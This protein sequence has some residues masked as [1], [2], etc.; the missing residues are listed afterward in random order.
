MFVPIVAVGRQRIHIKRLCEKCLFFY[1]NMR[2][3]LKIFSFDEIP[4][5]SKLVMVLQNYKLSL[6]KKINVYHNFRQF[7]FQI[8]YILLFFILILIE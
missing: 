4:L 7:T 2:K 6:E 5:K 3:L 8:I 1:R